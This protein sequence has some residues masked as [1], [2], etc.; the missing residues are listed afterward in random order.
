MDTTKPKVVQKIV[1]AVVLALTSAL[2][3][4]FF[5]CGGNSDEQVI[6]DGITNELESIKQLDDDAMDQILGSAASGADLEQYGITDEEFIRAWLSG[7]DYSV[8]DV[9]VNGNNATVDVTITCKSMSGIMV[10]F[11]NGITDFAS[12]DEAATMTQDELDTQ[13]GT[14]LLDSAND[15]ATQTTSISLPYV[16]NGNTWEP[17]AAFNTELSKALVG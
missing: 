1:L 11:Q 8:D 4:T 3:L 16:K 7:F 15:T 12:G 9:T 13:T 17:G 10:T 14:I 6:R 2:S 5:A